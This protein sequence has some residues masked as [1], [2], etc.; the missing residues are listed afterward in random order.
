M[1][2]QWL[3]DCIDTMTAMNTKDE[4][5]VISLG[6]NN[7]DIQNVHDVSPIL[8]NKKNQALAMATNYTLDIE[9]VRA[10]C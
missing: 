3:N 9:F 4:P 7:L 2:I 8:L 6:L 5:R 1:F 10:T